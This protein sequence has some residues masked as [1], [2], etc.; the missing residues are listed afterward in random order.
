MEN[1]LEE[2]LHGNPLTINYIHVGVVAPLLGYA[3][4]KV[5]EASKLGGSAADLKNVGMAL[6]VLAVIVLLYHV[7]RIYQKKQCSES[8]DKKV[9][10]LDLD[11]EDDS[12]EGYQRQ[13]KR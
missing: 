10:D 8:T 11:T 7:Y 13:A 12:T 9:N 4:W 6:L 1:K 2:L 3:G 5:H